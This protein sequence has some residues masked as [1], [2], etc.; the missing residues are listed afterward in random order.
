MLNDDSTTSEL[1][2]AYEAFVIEIQVN[3]ATDPTC[4]PN[5]ELFK[6]YRVYNDAY[7]KLMGA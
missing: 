7:N 5:S 2:T 3:L 1:T 4:E 6:T